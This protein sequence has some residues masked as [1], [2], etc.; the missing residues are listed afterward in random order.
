M[1]SKLFNL[2]AVYQSFHSL[3]SGVKI[4]HLN[5]HLASITSN[6]PIRI[7]DLGCG[8]GTN[9]G[10]FADKNR[11]CYLGVD[12]NPSYIRRASKKYPLRFECTDATKLE[13]RNNEFDLVLINSVLH[14]LSPE[15]TKK[16]LSSAADLLDVGGEC[17]VLD[18]VRPQDHGIASIVQRALIRLDR[19][20]YCRTVEQLVSEISEH[21]KI[22]SVQSF[23]IGLFGGM[24]WDLRLVVAVPKETRIAGERLQVS[25]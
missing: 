8:P 13:H 20:Q 25:R 7:I 11:Y 1:I 5:R 3:I 12:I 9:A 4:A 24:L 23:T 22:E 18:M 16:V 2:P 17:L 19:G 14:H 10:L 6:K 15:E 21:F